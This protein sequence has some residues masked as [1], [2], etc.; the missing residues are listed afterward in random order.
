[1]DFGVQRR[2]S[3][4]IVGTP[5]GMAV[6]TLCIL[7]YRVKK[8]LWEAYNYVQQLA[9]FSLRGTLNAELFEIVRYFSIIAIPSWDQM[10]PSQWN[11]HWAIRI[12]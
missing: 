3:V 10:T 5:E 8:E 11:S 6:A 4:G 2:L 7:R 12:D 1:M 9:P